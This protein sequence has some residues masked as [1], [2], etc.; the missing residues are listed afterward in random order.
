MCVITQEEIKSLLTFLLPRGFR[1]NGSGKYLLPHFFSKNW[2][3][4]ER[5]TPTTVD[6]VRILVESVGEVEDASKLVS[7]KIR[8]FDDIDIL[9]LLFQN[10]PLRSN[11]HTV[12]IVE[13]LVN[14][15]C[16]SF[17]EIEA[18]FLREP[19][20][21]CFY[22]E[23]SLQCILRVSHFLRKHLQRKQ[24][25][26]LDQT[27]LFWNVF[28]SYYTSPKKSVSMISFVD[29]GIKL[30][31]LIRRKTAEVILLNAV[32]R[33]CGCEALPELLQL[34]WEHDKSIHSRVIYQDLNSLQ[35][36]S[37][38]EKI[39]GQPVYDAVRKL[40]ELGA[41]VKDGANNPILLFLLTGLSSLSECCCDYGRRLELSISPFFDTVELIIDAAAAQKADKNYQEPEPVVSVFTKFLIFNI[42]TGLCCRNPPCSDCARPLSSRSPLRRECFSRFL[43]FVA[44]LVRSDLTRNAFTHVE[45]NLCITVVCEAYEDEEREAMRSVLCEHWFD[46]QR[47]LST[48]LQPGLA[49]SGYFCTVL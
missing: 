4:R 3:C 15:G 44:K 48:A 16:C 14:N 40:I 22:S 45:R 36:L 28:R 34:F 6:I 25:R 27:S 46:M 43:R 9:K 23:E 32:C 13:L 7:D 31:I 17:K 10:V 47:G 39:L 18:F 8:S 41:V 26:K 30:N 42:L 20:E 49:L 33:Y 29:C 21:A 38:N 12:P 11:E 19:F 2:V 24:K 35:M 1:V 37:S 5:C